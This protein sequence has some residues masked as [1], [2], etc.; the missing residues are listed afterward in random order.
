VWV[1]KLVSWCCSDPVESLGVS[2]KFGNSRQ[3][4]PEALVYRLLAPNLESRRE[5]SQNRIVDVAET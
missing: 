3:A 5:M 2:E 4:L 1:G